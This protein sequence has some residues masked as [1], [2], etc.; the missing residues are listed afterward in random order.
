MRSGGARG[1][2]HRRDEASLSGAVAGVDDNG[3]V[4]SLPDNRDSGQVESVTGR[5][6]EGPDA[7]LAQNHL[8]IALRENVFGGRDPF[9][10]RAGQ[11]A[12]E[13]HGPVQLPDLAQQVQVLHV[14]RADLNDAGILRD[15]LRL[16][17]GHHF[18]DNRK[19]D[20]TP[21]R[22]QQFQS[23]PAETLEG[24]GRR[25]GLEHAATQDMPAALQRCPAAPFPRPAQP[26]THLPEPANLAE[27]PGAVTGPHQPGPGPGAY[28]VLHGGRAGVAGQPGRCC[29]QRPGHP[30]RVRADPARGPGHAGGKRPDG[31]LGGRP[32]PDPQLHLALVP[33]SQI[34]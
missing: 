34:P 12:L 18:S 26:G 32:H 7:A 10:D 1:P 23:L 20:L 24:V 5:A 27:F 25:P 8:L 29:A 2:C 14:A 17:H 3:Q 33:G 4:R 15:T 28:L 9:L 21:G 16:F 6:V 30:A 22:Y 19:P 11:A 31:G 13:Q